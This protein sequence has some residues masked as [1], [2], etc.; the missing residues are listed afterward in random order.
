MNATSNVSYRY[1]LV[2][3]GNVADAEDLTSQTFMAAMEN[4]RQI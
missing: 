3:T 1:L 2:H 4:F